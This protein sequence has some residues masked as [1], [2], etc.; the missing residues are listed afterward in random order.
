MFLRHLLPKLFSHTHAFASAGL[1]TALL[2]I[3]SLNLSKSIHLRALSYVPWTTRKRDTL[4]K[5]RGGFAARSCLVTVF[6]GMPSAPERCSFMVIW[7]KGRMWKARARCLLMFVHHSLWL[8]ALRAAC[9]PGHA[10]ILSSC[11][12]DILAATAS[13]CRKRITAKSSC[14][15]CGINKGI[16]FT[17]GSGCPEAFL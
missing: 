15:S 2:R 10:E 17:I 12:Y 3:N 11:A 1:N 13:I 7:V 5:F 8:F 14:T 9:A 16:S 6:D 4:T